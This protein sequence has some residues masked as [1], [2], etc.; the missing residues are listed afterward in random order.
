MQRGMPGVDDLNGL[1]KALDCDDRQDGTK[2]F[3]A[4]RC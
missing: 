1:V 3:P 2:D 4:T